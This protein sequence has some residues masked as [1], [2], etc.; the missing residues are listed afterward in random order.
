MRLSEEEIR[1]ITLSAI[2]ELGE[3]ATPDQVRAVVSKSVGKL[4]SQKESVPQ[5]GK[6]SGRVILTSF[7]M[8]HPGIVAGI[9]KGLSDAQCDIKDIS[10][11]IMDEF[12]TMIMIIDITNSPQGL[13]EI[14]ERLNSIAEELN[15]K[16][17]LQHEDLFRFMHRI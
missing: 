9:T 3:K 5:E 13:N 8:N 16:V 7:G 17:Y 2:N 1:K 12:Y 14:Q 6:E 11:K 15:V 10:Q 4:E